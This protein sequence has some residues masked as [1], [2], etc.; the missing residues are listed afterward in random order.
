MEWKKNK[1]L[2]SQKE[3]FKVRQYFYS[4]HL[5]LE[6]VNSDN[7]IPFQFADEICILGWGKSEN[8]WKLSLHF[9]LLMSQTLLSL[10]FYHLAVKHT[11]NISLRFCEL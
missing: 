6:L 1:F 8:E 11:V 7:A 10:K 3:L 9:F 4:T 2:G 5:F